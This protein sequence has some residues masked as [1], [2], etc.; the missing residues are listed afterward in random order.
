MECAFISSWQISKIVER[1]IE[2]DSIAFELLTQMCRDKK[3]QVHG[4]ATSGISK[5]VESHLETASDAFELLSKM[6]GDENWHVR[7]PATS[8]I[9]RII[10]KFPIKDPDAFKLLLSLRQD[11]EWQVRKSTASGISKIVEN[12]PK[13]APDAFDLLSMRQDESFAVRNT[14]VAFCENLP[15]VQ[16]IFW[17]VVEFA[18]SLLSGNAPNDILHILLLKI[19]HLSASSILFCAWTVTFGISFPFAF[20]SS[21]KSTL[22]F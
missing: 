4:S 19:Y 2:K 3:W 5:I 8:G 7:R 14:I 12:Y 16:M 6:S 9:S 18:G 10:E 11:D 17:I 15:M 1:L 20:Q 22:A 13:K 21:R